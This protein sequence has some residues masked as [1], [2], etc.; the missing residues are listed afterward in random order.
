MLKLIVTV[1]FAVAF[2]ACALVLTLLR[3]LFLIGRLL[4]DA[5]RGRDQQ[6]PEAWSQRSGGRAAR[7][8]HD[9]NATVL[10]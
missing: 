4:A 10:A 6:S 9:E 3:F 7:A 2:L 5:V 1:L 8:E